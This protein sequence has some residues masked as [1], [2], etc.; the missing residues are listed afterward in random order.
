[1]SPV[2][3]LLQSCRV[4]TLIPLNSWPLKHLPTI[5]CWTDVSPCLFSAQRACD[6]IAGG[7][8]VLDVEAFH[9]RGPR[10]RR[11]PALFTFGEVIV[12]TA[13]WRTQ[14]QPFPPLVSAAASGVLWPWA[15]GDSM[16]LPPLLVF[17]PF[18]LLGLRLIEL[19][20]GREITFQ[21][22]PV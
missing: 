14:I 3:L 6:G 7:S 1:M 19:G 10:T 9:R 5:K 17:L 4:H 22:L 8:R 20:P 21:E 13:T 15:P 12:S 11:P 2:H 16:Q 18:L